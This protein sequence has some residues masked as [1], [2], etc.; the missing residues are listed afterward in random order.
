MKLFSFFLAD[1]ATVTFLKKKRIFGAA[2]IFSKFVNKT[3]CARVDLQRVN[4]DETFRL[5]ARTK[6]HH[7][8]LYKH[9][10]LSK[11]DGNG[12]RSGR[13]HNI[14]TS[15]SFRRPDFRKSLRV[16]L[17]SPAQ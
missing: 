15:G 2:V 6:S 7:Q 3:Q 13:I 5:K 14:G 4:N 16:L 8:E 9:G 17:E 1:N 12:L 10:D 11:T